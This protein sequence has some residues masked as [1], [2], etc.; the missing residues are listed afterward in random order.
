MKALPPVEYHPDWKIQEKRENTR[1][2]NIREY[3]VEGY[4]AGVQE[5]LVYYRDHLRDCLIDETCETSM[6]D[7][8]CMGRIQQL[9]TLLQ[10]IAGEIAEVDNG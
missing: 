1:R 5:T 4:L 8:Y 9:S 2:R 7:D 6:R 10:R 3:I